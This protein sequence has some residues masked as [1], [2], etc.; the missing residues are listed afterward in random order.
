LYHLARQVAADPAAAPALYLSCGTQDEL[1]GDNR[2]FHR[3]LDEA[4]YRHHYEEGPGAHEWAYWDGQ[5]AR[6]LDWLPLR[7]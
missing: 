3:H 5:I 7:K 1:L 2:A 4:G 6:V